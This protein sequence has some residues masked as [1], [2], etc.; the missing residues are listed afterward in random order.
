MREELCG[1]GDELLELRVSTSVCTGQCA[2]APNVNISIRGSVPAHAH[3]AIT[4]I[5]AITAIPA[6]RL[7]PCLEYAH[8]NVTARAG[9]CANDLV[10]VCGEG[11]AGMGGAEA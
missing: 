9:A 4:A 7:P 1:V 2:W 8:S 11:V 5:T 6:I 3:P 10:S